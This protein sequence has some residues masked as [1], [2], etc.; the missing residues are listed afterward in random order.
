M[1]DECERLYGAPCY[2]AHRADLLAVLERALP[3]ERLRV[4]HLCVEVSQDEP[5]EGV[6][7]VDVH[8]A[9][10]D[11]SG[12][13]DLVGVARGRQARADIEE[14]ADT[15][16]SRQIPD[17]ATQERPI[18]AGAEVDVRK[19]R[20]DLVAVLLRKLRGDRGS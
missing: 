4:D 10:V 1:G 18:D 9:A 19:E 5:L 14:R 20:P 15:G 6:A 2:V 13:G 16:I 11:C 12:L 7:A 3:R 8:D 17:S